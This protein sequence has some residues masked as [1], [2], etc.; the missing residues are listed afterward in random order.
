MNA[1][2][3][4][5]YI[6]SAL[7]LLAMAALLFL[8]AWTLD[9]WQAWFYLLVFGAC[10]LVTSAYFLKHDPRLVERRMR[11]GMTAEREPT[12]QIIQAVAG[13]LLI[14]L[15]VVAGF[16]R[17]F[18]RSSVSPSVVIAADIMVALGFFIVFLTLKE[19]TFAAS[20]I[21][22][23]KDQTVVSTAPYA[24]VRHP[25][26]TGALLMFLASPLALGSIWALTVEA[27]LVVVLA[28]RLLDE[29]KFLSANLPHYTDYC[30]RVRYRLIP[31][32]W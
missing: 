27:F 14:S 30:S 13:L 17:H 16:D 3:K 2:S 26:Y 6:Q 8:P 12:Q 23:E 31:F 11:V 15:Y 4:K 18:G 1:L 29:E 7:F 22:V 21:T 25:M 19:N 20:T 24:V 9:Y 10:M 32:V 5:V 28:V